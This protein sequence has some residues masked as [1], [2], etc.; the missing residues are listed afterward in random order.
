MRLELVQ[1]AAKVRFGLHPA[2][3]E[4]EASAFQLA[5]YQLGVGFAVLRNQYPE[6]FGHVP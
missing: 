4:I 1:L 6:R 2:A 5:L 3:L